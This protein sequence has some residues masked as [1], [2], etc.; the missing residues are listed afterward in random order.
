MFHSYSRSETKAESIISRKTACLY[1]STSVIQ[2]LIQAEQTQVFRS[3]TTCAYLLYI[4][5]RL[6][7]NAFAKNQLQTL[8]SSGFVDWVADDFVGFEPRDLSSGQLHASTNLLAM[9]P[10]DERFFEMQLRSYLPH[11]DQYCKRDKVKM[12][13]SSS[14]IGWSAKRLR[15]LL[16]LEGTIQRKHIKAWEKD[17]VS[18]LHWSIMWFSASEPLIESWGQRKDW[19]EWLKLLTEVISAADNLHLMGTYQWR[20]A[21]DLLAKENMPTTIL[22]CFFR[23]A[24]R[25]LW[26]RHGSSRLE[27]KLSLLLDVLTSC[28]VDLETFGRREFDIWEHEHGAKHIRSVSC[29]KIVDWNWTMSRPLRYPVLGCGELTNDLMVAI[30]Y[31]PKREDWFIECDRY[32][33]YA[34]V[35]WNMVENPLEVEVMPGSWIDDDLYSACNQPLSSFP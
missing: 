3:R 35:F 12:V 27:T 34:E 8:L 26:D 10:P 11:W 14:G 30:H 23:V 2:G 20:C 31:G 21:W 22:L 18:L 15:R 24:N 9:C 19:T 32:W 33:D 4:Y 5:R 1:G 17:G 25:C 29:V 6:T 7:F 28:G 16:D 13:S